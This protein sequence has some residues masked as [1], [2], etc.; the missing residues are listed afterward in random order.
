[1][2]RMQTMT[3]AE[4]T[5]KPRAKKEAILFLAMLLTGLFLLPVVVYVIGR[6]VFGA[7]DGGSF[8]TFYGMLH[9]DFRAGEPAVWFLILSP[10]LIWMLF[11]L[12]V[13]GFRHSREADKSAAQ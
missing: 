12:T 11:R 13:K 2:I 7:Y 5:P 8:A 3:T 1:M 4:N 6:T 9:S 10:Y